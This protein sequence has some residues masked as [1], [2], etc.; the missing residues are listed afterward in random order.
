MPILTKELTPPIIKC[1]SYPCFMAGDHRANEQPALVAMHTLWLREH[2]RIAKIIKEDNPSW[3]SDTIFQITRKIVGAEMQ[4]IVYNEF[5]PILIGS[6]YRTLIPD[7]DGYNSKVVPNIPNSFAAAAFRFGHS[8]IRDTFSFAYRGEIKNRPQDF[9]LQTSFF[10]IAEFVS[11]G[12]DAIL[13]GLLKD[14]LQMVDNNLNEVLTGG[15]FAPNSSVPGLDLAALNIERGR[16]HGLPPYIVWKEWAKKKCGIESHFS[17]RAR[18]S[19]GSLYG[20]G[21][22]NNQNLDLFVGGISEEPVEGGVTGAT[23]T[24][25]MSQTFRQLRDGDRFYYE[26]ENVFTVPQIAET[27]KVTL[28]RILCDN[29]DIAYIQ[30]N[31]FL[32]GDERVDCKEI[33]PVDL[34]VWYPTYAPAVT[35]TIQ[36]YGEDIVDLLQAVMNEIKVKMNTFGM[37]QEEEFANIY[38]STE[39]SPIS[40]T[41]G[42][43]TPTS[44]NETPTSDDET[45]MNDDETSMSDDETSM[46]DGETSMNNDDETTMSDSVA[47][48]ADDGAIMGGLSKERVKTDEELLSI[49]EEL[50]TAMKKR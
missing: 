44:G 6:N 1:P 25:I 7:Y 42:D 29:S 5:L 47:S 10:N 46:S 3:C 48:V 2:N 37:K 19:I 15:L 24:C 34:K 26:N 35:S 39:E 38:Q 13:R 22:E 28:S 31:A 9:N 45:S 36:S 41:R 4:A 20:R 32:N 14:P 27:G 8:L 49:L 17:K 23:F 30:P 33:P 16:D 12:P 18:R 43:E 40:D 11:T 21:N 50:L